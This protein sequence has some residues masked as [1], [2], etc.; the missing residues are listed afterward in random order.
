MPN[1]P[2]AHEARAAAV[3]IEGSTRLH[4]GAMAVYVVVGGGGRGRLGMV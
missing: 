2:C 1:E 3:K 4:H